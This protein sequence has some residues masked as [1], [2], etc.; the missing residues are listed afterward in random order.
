MQ[1]IRNKKFLITGVSR[2]PA[3]KIVRYLTEHKIRITGVDVRFPSYN[4]PEMKFYETDPYLSN[5]AN[6]C[7]K[8]K[9]EIVIHLMFDYDIYSEIH[10]YN[11]NNFIRFERLFR[12][13]KE[14][15]FE[16]L[17]LF[18]S[19]FVYGVNFSN[20]RR[21]SESDILLSGSSVAYLNDM[22]VI[23]RYL[24]AYFTENEN[25]GLFLFRAVPLYHNFSEE[26]LIKF[27]KRT[28]VFYSIA[29][30]DPEYQFLYFTDMINYIL[31][32]VQGDNG[33]IY[34]IA[35]SD[36]IRLSEIASLVNRPFV[37]IPEGISRSI[38]GSARLLFKSEI[39][40]TELIDLLSF[41]CLVSIDKARRF[42]GYEPEYKCRDIV[43]NITFFD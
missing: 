14:G 32:S 5:I 17:Y 3:N 30:R 37:Y 12:Y 22:L 25:K 29:G 2:F 6:I 1:R 9:T 19:S 28:P 8:E 36:T 16:K 34:N 27:F 26:I 10:P 31:N 24:S 39:Y 15:L 40:S 20:N 33:G 21:F 42:L 43:E 18:S 23:E 7:K 11:R 35:S 38:F 4:P 41:P 13:Y